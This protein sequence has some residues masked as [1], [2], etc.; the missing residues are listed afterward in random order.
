VS[1]LP[2]SAREAVYIA[3]CPEHGLHGERSECFVC[4]G[5]VERVLMAPVSPAVEEPGEALRYSPRHVPTLMIHDGEH[6]GE[7]VRASNYDAV[8]EGRRD[9][10]EESRDLSRRLVEAVEE[11]T[12]L[13]AETLRQGQRI[14]E[15]DAL[16]VASEENAGRLRAA[17][18][19]ARAH[20][21]RLESD[22]SSLYWHAEGE[23]PQE[24][25][26]HL[27]DAI[28]DIRAA[29]AGSPSQETK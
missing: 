16:L 19:E 27:T 20:L 23:G 10:H 15:R 9:A 1:D 25:P 6:S 4:G 28:E 5:P 14:T 12:R 22:L 29:L 3:R 11:A 2:E 7:W 21:T 13:R 18:D 24:P 17:N 26:E 8:Y